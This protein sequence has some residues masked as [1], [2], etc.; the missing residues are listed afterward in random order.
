MCQIKV[1][2][3]GRHHSFGAYPLKSLYIF[4]RDVCDS[5]AIAIEIIIALTSSSN[6]GANSV[7]EQYL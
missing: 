4:G 3:G 6:E 1:F 7:I 2:V 5:A